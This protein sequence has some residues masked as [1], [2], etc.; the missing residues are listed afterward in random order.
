MVERTTSL[1][2]MR[3]ITAT[4]DPSRA[5]IVVIL[6]SWN[7]PPETLS[8]SSQRGQIQPQGD[9]NPANPSTSRQRRLEDGTLETSSEHLQDI[10]PIPKFPIAEKKRK[11]SAHLISHKENITKRKETSTKMEDS[12]RR[13]V[14]KEHK[15]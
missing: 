9:R 7:K 14:T 5:S 12:Y 13:K 1:G 3:I 15:F 10:S 2:L 8:V 6:S 11:H 4:P